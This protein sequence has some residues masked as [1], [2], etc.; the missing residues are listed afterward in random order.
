MLKNPDV[1][2]SASMNRWILSI[3][4]FHFTLVHVPGSHHGLD[5]L[6]R[7]QLQPGDKEEDE[8][9]GFEDWVDK[10]NG[11]IHMINPVPGYRFQA[12][13]MLATPPIACY[14]SESTRD[15]TTPPEEPDEDLMLSYE[16]VPHSEKAISANLKI[17]HIWQW[18]HTL[19]RL[20][21][22]IDEEYKTF[23]RCCTEFFLAGEDDRL[24]RKDL[25]GAHKIVIPQERRLFLISSSHNDVGHH[26]FYAT[27]ALLAEWYWWSAMG[28]DVAWF[29]K[30]CHL[31]Q[32]RKT[33]Q[34]SIPPTVATPAPLFLKVYMDTMHLTP[35][36]GFKYIVQACCSLT[37]WPEWEML[38]QESAKS[39]AR[40]ILNNIIYRWGVRYWRSSQTMEPPSSKQWTI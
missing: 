8:D 33:Q 17:R 10:V 27:N 35:S 36:A 16:D 39:L 9:D 26:G 21:E 28:Q 37:H 32:L 22:I 11:F 13:F 19:E 25:R 34:V 24:W 23:M 7:R 40:F 12:R 29:V 4:L 18:L 20:R 6:S 14:I 38:R 2:P 1:A 5:G 31:C 15:H 30:T 3:L